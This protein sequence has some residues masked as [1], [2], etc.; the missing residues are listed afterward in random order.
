MENRC[1]SL[2]CCVFLSELARDEGVEECDCERLREC[3]AKLLHR[4]LWQ[5]SEVMLWPYANL[6]G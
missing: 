6:P 1:K 3:C 5:T 2:C 4:V